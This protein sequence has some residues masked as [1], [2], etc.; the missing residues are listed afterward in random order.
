MPSFLTFNL[1]RAECSHAPPIVM[2]SSVLPL[3]IHTRSHRKWTHLA[4]NETTDTTTISE[5]GRTHKLSEQR[6]EDT[7]GLH[8]DLTQPWSVCG[9]KAILDDQ[10]AFAS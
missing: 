6:G 9:L 4:S 5:A 10:A 8:D 3:V 7:E 2:V 1:Y